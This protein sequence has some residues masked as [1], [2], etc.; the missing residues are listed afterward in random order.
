LLDNDCK[1]YAVALTFGLATVGLT[2]TC[3]SAADPTNGLTPF[4]LSILGSVLTGLAF[5]TAA[6]ASYP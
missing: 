4:A 5:Y 6:V 3:M 1:N 2:L